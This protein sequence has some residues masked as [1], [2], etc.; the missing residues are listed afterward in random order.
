MKPAEAEIPYLVTRLVPGRPGVATTEVAAGMGRL[1]R[2]VHALP[3]EGAGFFKESPRL[4][5][6]AAEG[7]W[8]D[9]VAGMADRLGP[10]A[11]AGILSP[12]LASRCREFLLDGARWDEPCVFAH[13]DF[14]LR[15]VLSAG[16]G[17][18]A[19]IDWA[20]CAAAP[21]WLD[22]AR[23]DFGDARLRDAMLAGYFPEGVPADAPSRLA[24]HRLLYALL[25]LVWEY[26]VGGDWLHERLP[27]IESA[28]ATAPHSAGSPGR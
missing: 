5:P 13:G 2:A 25:A 19:V 9:Q 10:V 26:E 22:L 23:A 14:H 1:L 3:V 24:D 20:D 4:P 8:G 15:H 28:L 11:A 21:L 12:A 18:E 16:S 7:T 27:G 17:I 6:L